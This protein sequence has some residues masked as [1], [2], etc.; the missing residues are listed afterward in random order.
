MIEIIADQPGI[1]LAG[2]AANGEEALELARQLS[3]DVIVMDVSMPKMDGIEATRRIKV[4]M[5]EVRIIGLSMFDDEDI[6]R[7][8]RQAGADG[9][10]SKSESSSELLKVIY[11]VAGLNGNSSG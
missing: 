9:F 10:A 7:K 8:M 6:T 3:P 4:E 5:P 1:Q 2:E 11:E